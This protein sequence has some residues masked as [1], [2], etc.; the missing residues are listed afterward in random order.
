MKHLIFTFA[1]LLT[2]LSAFGM[3]IT[4]WATATSKQQTTGRVLVFRYADKFRDNFQE[5][6]FPHRV[7]IVWKYQSDTGMP[8]L[9]EREAMD[10]MEDMLE[11]LVEKLGISVL[12]LVSTGE[13]AREWIFYTK[14]E[15]EFIASLN[16]SLPKESKFPIEIHTAPD[17]SWSSYKDFIRWVR[18]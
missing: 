15:A 12:T 10:Q 18:R 16:S 5:S 2:N 13:N 1:F 14:S 3:E 9:K 4:Q 17:P 11:P 6:V 8:V 7:I